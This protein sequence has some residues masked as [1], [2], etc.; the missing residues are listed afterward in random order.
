MALIQE[1]FRAAEAGT[2]SLFIYGHIDYVDIY[3]DEQNCTF[4]YKVLTPD[5]ER[6]RLQVWPTDNSLQLQRGSRELRIDGDLQQEENLR[7][8]LLA[9]SRGLFCLRLGSA[10]HARFP[11]SG[12]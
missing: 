7:L 5:G 8:R 12:D 11:D 2:I 3:G 10:C 4:C 1:R 9:P 6:G